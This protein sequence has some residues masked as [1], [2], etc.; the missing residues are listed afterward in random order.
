[1]RGAA[2]SVPLAP[3]V[4]LGAR[5][6]AA[7]VL[8]EVAR[9]EDFVH[10]V[11]AQTSAAGGVEGQVFGWQPQAADADVAESAGGAEQSQSAQVAD[12]AVGV[13]VIAAGAQQ[14]APVAQLAQA[15]TAVQEV[16]EGVEED[17]EG[18]ERGRRR[19]HA[20]APL[21]P[22]RIPLTDEATE[23]P[24]SQGIVRAVDEAV[25][26]DVHAV[27]LIAGMLVGLFARL[28][29]SGL[30]QEAVG[31]RLPVLAQ[32]DVDVAALAVAGLAVAGGHALPLEQ[33][34]VE[35]GVG[36]EA[37]EAD[38]HAVEAGVGLLDLER[39]RR[40]L[41]VERTGRAQVG[42]QGVQPVEHD[43]QQRLRMRQPM[44]LLPL[45][46]SQSTEE[47]RVGGRTPQPGT[48]EREEGL[49]HHGAVS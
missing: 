48:D 12:E 45:G 44:K 41:Q 6:D 7:V 43:G 13:D 3:P 21:G 38:N 8:A 35:A 32:I 40:P 26:L 18:V 31:T 42:G 19:G 22:L 29:R 15:D 11:F 47:D 49:L 10:Q 20:D 24:V 1:M 17:V 5:R 4:T 37:V 46:G 28:L 34:G 30:E 39:L 36:V 25:V 9:G 16:L 23:A 14:A 27:Q 33:D 2:E